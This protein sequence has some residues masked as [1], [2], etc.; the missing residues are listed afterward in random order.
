MFEHI[1]VPLRLGSADARLIEPALG[2]ARMSQAEVTL[3]HVVEKIAG[4]P[5]A[6]LR[7]FH[8]GLAKRARKTLERHAKAF[9]R[10]GVPVT[11]SVL[12]GKAP[13]EIV[14]FAMSQEVDLIVMGSHCVRADDE[15]R[16][17]GTTSYKVG[18]LCQCPVF[19]VKDVE[20][21]GKAR[22]KRRRSP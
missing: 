11:I 3:V 12:L 22:T 10:E 14:R 1:L 20:P 2:L 21:V 15:A 18:L 8:E 16:G 6:E 19:L 13:A 7:R 17:W 9:S 4:L 5:G